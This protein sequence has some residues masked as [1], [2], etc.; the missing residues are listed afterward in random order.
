MSS[1]I[2]YPAAALDMAQALSM[3]YR[4]LMV[5][6]RRLAGGLGVEGTGNDMEIRLANMDAAQTQL[7]DAELALDMAY[8]VRSQV[9]KHAVSTP[10]HNLGDRPE[11]A[12]M[13][14]V[15]MRGA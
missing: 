8:F 7:S 3:A 13:A 15:Q 12:R 5:S 4:E 1:A 6:A 14:L 2:M 9:K 11:V 10:V